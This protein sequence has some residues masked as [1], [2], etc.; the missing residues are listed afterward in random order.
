[1]AGVEEAMAPGGDAA[2]KAA[3]VRKGHETFNRGDIDGCLALLTEDIEWH[4][5]FGEAM[6][7][8]SIYEGRDGF[9]RYFEQ[10]NE[11][12]EGFTV[13]P[14]EIAVAGDYVVLDA[15]VRGRGRASGVDISTQLTIVWKV[16][17]SL[18]SWGATYFNR[19]EA[20]AAV[21]LSERELEPSSDA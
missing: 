4:P 9:R 17:G 3:L 21:G 8:A 20:L 13:A 12:I 7:G 2:A 15:D 5:A 18:L 11:V 1:V 19:D 6:I 16:R 10:V 14:R